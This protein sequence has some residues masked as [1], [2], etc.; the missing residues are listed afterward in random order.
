MWPLAEENRAPFFAVA[1]C[2][3]E[4][5][6]IAPQYVGSETMFSAIRA[7]RPVKVLRESKPESSALILTGDAYDE[8]AS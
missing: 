4:Q 5:F 8:R 7:E 6:I 3:A 1:I 2:E